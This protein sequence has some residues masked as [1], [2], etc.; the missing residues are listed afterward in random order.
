[1]EK[2]TQPYLWCSLCDRGIRALA[3]VRLEALPFP[4]SKLHSVAL[5]LLLH[6]GHILQGVWSR[7]RARVHFKYI[8]NSPMALF[9]SPM[10][11]EWSSLEC[12]S[13]PSIPPPET[14]ALALSVQ[15]FLQESFRSPVLLVQ[16][17]TLLPMTDAEHS[18][19]SPY[20]ALA[21]RGCCCSVREQAPKLLLEVC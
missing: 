4:S 3:Y 12:H 13:I 15:L 18:P 8:L 17:V 6:Q 14:S 16:K 20:P 2:L 7:I 21:A 1:M 9:V 11:C 5:E 10:S 19:G